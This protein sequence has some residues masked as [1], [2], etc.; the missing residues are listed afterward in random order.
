[1]RYHGETERERERSQG[2]VRHQASEKEATLE[3]N[4][5]ASDNP[6]DAMCIRDILAS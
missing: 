3:S 6:A 4:P 1:M 5:V 2:T